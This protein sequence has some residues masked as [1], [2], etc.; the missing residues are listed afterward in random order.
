M[1]NSSFV[2]NAY[3][4]KH[5]VDG[6][7]RGKTNIGYS[8]NSKNPGF[9]ASASLQTESK[10]FANFLIAILNNKILSD[11]SYQEFLKIQ[12]ISLATKKSKERK[13]GLGIVIEKSVYGTNYS[14]GGD[15]LSN[16][17]LYMF[18]KEK[19]IGYVFFTNSENKNKFNKNLLDFLL[20]R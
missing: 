17:A 1:N 8:S 16:T 5:R 12:S 20:S 11:K 2:W 18:N 15:N 7:F 19:K 6:H 13:Y 14:H 4:E 10:E 3:I 9:K